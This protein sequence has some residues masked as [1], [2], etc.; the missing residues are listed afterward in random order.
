M[1]VSVAA[2]ATLRGHIE[3]ITFHNAE[4]HFTIARF[5]AEGGKLISV[6]GHLPSPNPGETLEIRGRW[7]THAKFG[8]QLKLESFDVVLPDSIEGIRNYL[9]SGVI[10][11]VGPRVVDRLVDRFGQETLT[12]IE[13]QPLKL[14][15][16][17]GIGKA[18]AR[19]IAETWNRHHAVRR[20]MDFL[21]EHDLPV[22]CSAKILKAYGDRALEVIRTQPF[23]MAADIPGVG[24]AMADRIAQNLGLAQDDPERVAACIRNVLEQAV[25]EGH[26]FIPE[27]QLVRDCHRLFSIDAPRSAEAVAQLH[28]AREIVVETDGEAG[29]RIVYPFS[30]YQAEVG[31]ARRLA[32]YLSV[33]AAPA[34]IGARDLTQVVLSRLSIELSE[35]Q[36]DILQRV[37]SHQ[38]MIITGGPGTGKTT[39][40]RSVAVVFELM[41]KRMALAAPTG[42][43]SRRLAEVTGRKAT[44]IHK[45]LGYDP[46]EK[47]FEKNPDHP[48]SADVVIVDEASMIDTPL[49]YHLLQ[50]VSMQAVLILVGD[51]FQLPSVGPGNVLADLIES[52]RVPFYELTEIFRQAVQSTIVTNA[53]RIRRGQVP[54]LDPATDRETLSEFYFIERPFPEAVAETMVDICSDHIPRRFGLDPFRDIQ[55]LTP[56]HKGETGTLRLN[57]RLQAA[58]NPAD[59]GQESLRGFRVGDKVMHLKNNY[60]KEIFNGDI[61]RVQAVDGKQ[62]KLS[63]DFYDRIVPYDTQELEELSLAYA[64]TVHK[65]Q[66]SEYPAVVVAL[67][68]EHFPLLQRNLLYTALTRGKSLVVLV[69]TRRALEIAIA[70]DAPGQRLSA[71]ARRLRAG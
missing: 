60:F 45:L 39:L 6:L 56:M 13:R 15:E 62:R 64:T 14:A 55:V 30:L 16:V 3:R 12:I 54:D 26:V 46:V 42:R 20:L 34:A 36:V 63:V 22:A 48:L 2:V 1:T 24:F 61:G 31:I 37:L 9:K 25:A 21:R 29:Q 57:E 47:M 18:T 17:K 70:N 51:V 10:K 66:G 23:R 27:A 32:A 7:Q 68:L 38:M 71:L 50:A 65:S 8:P 33:A 35:P 41:G 69:G 40:I 28:Q 11:G 59:N 49:M 44:T 52:G 67:S 4:T 53:H 58:L 43:A 19:R 5:R